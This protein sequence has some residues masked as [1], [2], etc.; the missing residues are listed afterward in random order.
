[1]ADLIRRDQ[2]VHVITGSYD[3]DQI[4]ALYGSLDLTV[5]TRFHSVIFSLT[6]LVPALAI[7]YEHKTGGIMK[8][9]GLSEWV[10]DI[11]EVTG[12]QLVELY[13]QLVLSAADY[14]THLLRVLPGYVERAHHAADEIERRYR[15]LA[16][17]RRFST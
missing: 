7:E 17:A 13:D 6:A 8:D 12:P 5:G 15:E 1:V 11:S 3:C 14:R 10:C 9:L 2:H 4:K 16:A